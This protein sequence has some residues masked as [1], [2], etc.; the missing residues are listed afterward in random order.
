MVTFTAFTGR[1]AWRAWQREKSE[2]PQAALV[3]A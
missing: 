3:D 2:R 1:V